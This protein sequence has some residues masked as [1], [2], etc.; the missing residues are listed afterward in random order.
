MDIDGNWHFLAVF[1]RFLSEY[2]NSHTVF[3]VIVG[4]ATEQL[5]PWTPETM[6]T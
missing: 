5:F 3:A 6:S 2:I 4:F 1:R